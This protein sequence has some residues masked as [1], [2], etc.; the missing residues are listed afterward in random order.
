[1]ASRDDGAAKKGKRK[2]KNEYGEELDTGKPK[3]IPR[4]LAEKDAQRRLIVV[5]ENASLETI[6]VK[7]QTLASGAIQ[8]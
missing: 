3:K 1:M 7:G 8:G 2:V 5:L 6:K 4:T